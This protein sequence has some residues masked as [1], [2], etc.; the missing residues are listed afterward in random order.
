MQKP[1]GTVARQSREE[2]KILNFNFKVFLQKEQAK[3]NYQAAQHNQQRSIANDA[4]FEHSEIDF[5]ANECKW[6]GLQE[7]PQQIQALGHT[8]LEID[9]SLQLEFTFGI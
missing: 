9:Q 6:D 8:C 1:G 3:A 5:L 2:N 7:L 4:T